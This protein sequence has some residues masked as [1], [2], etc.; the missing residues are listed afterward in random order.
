[1]QATSIAAAQSVYIFFLNGPST[2]LLN[3]PSTRFLNGPS[4]RLLNGPSTRF[5]NGPS[6]RLFLNNV[7]VKISSVFHKSCRLKHPL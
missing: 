7:F 6:T 2:R 5:L 3:G 4:T 1:M